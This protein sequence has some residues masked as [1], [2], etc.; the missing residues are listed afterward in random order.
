MEVTELTI[1]I[2]RLGVLALMYLFMLVLISA[3]RADARAATAPARPTEIPHAKPAPEPIKVEPVKPRTAAA[4]VYLKGT[5]PTTGRE[6]PLVVSMDIGRGDACTISIPNRFVSTRHARVF[7]L[8]GR[9]VVEDLG[10]TN[11]TLLNSQQ[12]VSVQ[13]LKPGDHL[14]VG[15][16]DF[17]AK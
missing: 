9:W 16:T 1:W 17:L 14:T 3:L 11:G 7:S 13:P 15:D 6:Y 4:L 5:L 10:S 2:A 8:D 12:L